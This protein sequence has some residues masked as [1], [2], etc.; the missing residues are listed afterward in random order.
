MKIVGGVGGISGR[1]C[2]VVSLRV[3][4][5]GDRVEGCVLLSRFA[6]YTVGVCSTSLRQVTLQ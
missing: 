3:G 2:V 4:L 1:M 6:V 5:A